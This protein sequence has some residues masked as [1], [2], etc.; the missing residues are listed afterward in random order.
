MRADGAKGFWLRAIRAGFFTAI[1]GAPPCETWSAARFRAVLLDDGGP[2]PLRSQAEPWGLCYGSW[3][4]QKQLLVANDLLQVWISMMVAAVGSNT[5]FIM[6]HPAPSKFVL[7]AP[8]VW[9]LAEIHWLELLPLAQRHLV[10]Q[11][12]YGA[13]SA[14]PTIFFVHKLAKFQTVLRNWQDPNTSPANWVQ[15]S[16]KD[17]DGT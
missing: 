5:S 1:L 12:Y 15:L 6:E 4:N 17:Q 3:R 11:G 2:K 8:S 9:K 10:Y 13:P 7:E 16:G 14:K